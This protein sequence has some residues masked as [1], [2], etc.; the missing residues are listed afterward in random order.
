MLINI[1][2]LFLVIFSKIANI[3]KQVQ[4][5]VYLLVHE[6][7][8]KLRFW[9]EVSPTIWLMVILSQTR[10]DQLIQ[11]SRKQNQEE[12]IGHLL[13]MDGKERV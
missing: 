8:A 1:V 7:L 13:T 10:T 2:V 12:V 5:K 3:K 9:N 4:S 11:S 6:L